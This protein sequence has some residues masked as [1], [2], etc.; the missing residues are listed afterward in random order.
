MDID[1]EKLSLKKTNNATANEDLGKFSTVKE[2]R[3]TLELKHS[4]I[5]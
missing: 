1:L 5:P 4:Q 2:L 3:F